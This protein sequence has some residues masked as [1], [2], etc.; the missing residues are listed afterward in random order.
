MHTQPSARGGLGSTTGGPVLILSLILL[1]TV[2]ES[3]TVSSQGTWKNLRSAQLVAPL[4]AQGLTNGTSIPFPPNRSPAP[5]SSL[6]SR[7][8]SAFAKVGCL[9]FSVPFAIMGVDELQSPA[10]LWPVSPYL[11]HKPAI[12]QS[13]FL[14]SQFPTMPL[15]LQEIWQSL[16]CKRGER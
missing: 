11:S 8:F 12:C 6:R 2:A 16:S 4:L 1:S 9:D 10:S 3:A 13:I 7:P 5:P 14:P 15:V